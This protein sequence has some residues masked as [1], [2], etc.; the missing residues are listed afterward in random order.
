MNEGICGRSCRQAVTGTDQAIHQALAGLRETEAILRLRRL[1][2]DVPTH[3]RPCGQTDPLGV[4]GRGSS[5]HHQ[6]EVW[7]QC[8]PESLAV[9]EMRDVLWSDWENPERILSGIEKIWKRPALAEDPL[10]FL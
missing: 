10:P 6:H 2:F 9:M 1:S 4:R 5:P 7:P 3:A 8:A